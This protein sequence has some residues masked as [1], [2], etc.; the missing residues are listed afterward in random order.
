MR[1]GVSSDD[2][3]V[4]SNAV[5]EPLP[6]V[7]VAN[8]AGS[9]NL[10]ERLPDGLRNALARHDALIENQA[11]LHGG[12]LLRRRGDGDSRLI[13]FD[14]PGAAAEAAAAMMRAVAHEPWTTSVPLR[15][16]LALASSSSPAGVDLAGA[17]DQAQRLYAHARPDQALLAESCALRLEAALPPELSL[18]ALGA[19]ALAPGTPSQQVFQLVVAGLPDS[20]A[21]LPPPHRC[22]CS[23]TWSTC[24]PPRRCWPTCWP[25]RP[26]CA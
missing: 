9:T 5:P 18:R 10:W 22:C 6:T 7:L 14:S 23:T 15:V 12:Q 13:R 11:A 8:I 25:P 19:L 3:N 20:P 24:P 17:I 21:T 2:A 4:P 1:A 26:R 16:R